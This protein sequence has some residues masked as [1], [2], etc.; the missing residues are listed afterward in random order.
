M[1]V[2]P[3]RLGAEHFALPATVVQ[4]IIPYVAPRQVSGVAPWFSGV[5]LL[6]GQM[7][8]VVDV[9]MLLVGTKARRELSTRIIIVDCSQQFSGFSQLG[10]LLEGITS[11]MDIAMADI[12]T[13]LNMKATPWF[14]G[15]FEHGQSIYQLLDWQ[16]L[17]VGELSSLMADEGI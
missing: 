16:G 3:F 7:V 17:V 2:I 15:S 9:A 5:L 11:A 13:G 4:K 6:S 10:L 14:R 1:L 12:S 8:P